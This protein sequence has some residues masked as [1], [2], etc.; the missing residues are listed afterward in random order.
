M[1]IPSKRLTSQFNECDVYMLYY[2]DLS[3]DGVVGCTTSFGFCV[4]LLSRRINYI[5]CILVPGYEHNEC[6]EQ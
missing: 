2:A 4:V 3:T 6:D 5:A 1:I